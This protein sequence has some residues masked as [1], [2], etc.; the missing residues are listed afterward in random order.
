MLKDVAVINLHPKA[1][2]C[3]DEGEISQQRNMNQIFMY[4]Q[5]KVKM[6]SIHRACL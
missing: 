2:S 5:Q 6:R 3:G 1:F 4:L